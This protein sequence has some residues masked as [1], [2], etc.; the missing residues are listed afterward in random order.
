MVMV[1]RPASC[2]SDVD[3]PVCSVSRCGSD[4]VISDFGTSVAHD[5]FSARTQARGGAGTVLYNAPE[6]FRAAGGEYDGTAADVWALGATLHAMV[7]GE[8]PYPA[9]SHATA[10]QVAAAVTDAA[11]W[12]CG[13][14]CDEPHLLALLSGML[15]KGPAERLTL[16]QVQAAPWNASAMSEAEAGASCP[17]ASWAKITLGLDDAA[18]AVAQG[19]MVV[20][21]VHRHVYTS[22]EATRRSLMNSLCSCGSGAA[23][24]RKCTASVHPLWA[25][26]VDE[27]SATS[28]TPRSRSLRA[29][30]Q[31]ER[32]AAAVAGAAA[33]AAAAAAV[34]ATAAARAAVARAAVRAAAIGHA[35]GKPLDAHHG[36]MMR[37]APQSA[38]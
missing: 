30:E 5:G 28:S 22:L 18:A 16:E 6:K 2:Y 19:Q 10:A 7:F 24:A 31:S 38:S 1:Q 13:F 33:A 35:I 20:R 12:R 23:V 21:T 29:T 34:G 37:P 14:G 27:S 25:T 9:A 17:E 26:P 4:A 11:E 36:P 15:R 8:L 3:G 32:V